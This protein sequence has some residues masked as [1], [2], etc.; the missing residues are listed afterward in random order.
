[1]G[2]FS[3]FFSQK[4]LMILMD[5]EF[6]QERLSEKDALDLRN[7]NDA[8]WNV[9][10]SRCVAVD[11]S[12]YHVTATSL[13]GIDQ[14][15][16]TLS[17]AM[18]WANKIADLSPVFKMKWLKRLFVSDLPLLRNIEGIDSL[19]NLSYL[20]LSGNRGSLHPPLRLVSLKPIAR[21]AKLE[22]LT[23]ANVRLDDDD[24]TPIASIS[25]LRDLTISCKFE[26]KQLAFL[27][28]RLNPQLMQPITA[29][30]ELNSVCTK[31]GGPLYL[32]IGRKMPLLCKA[33]K[34]EKFERLSLQ[35]ER[36]V[37]ES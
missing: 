6:S 19:Q 15:H 26:R 34:K 3:S 18:E 13:D 36:L 28:K 5:R 8:A 27:A 24:V 9:I 30:L 1:M 16:S 21:L 23:V 14:L 10:R 32:F 20:H 17:L 4:P 25:S 33:C 37:A 11:L 31:C 22:T 7:I 35:F 12:L 29:Y 2:L